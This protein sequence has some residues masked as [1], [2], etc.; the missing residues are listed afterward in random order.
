M[1]GI[2]GHLGECGA[3]LTAASIILAV[4]VFFLTEG[5]RSIVR[6]RPLGEFSLLLAIGGTL[7]PGSIAI[8]SILLFTITNLSPCFFTAL[9]CLLVSAIA[10]LIFFTYLVLGFFVSPIRPLTRWLFNTGTQVL[11]EHDME[12]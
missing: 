8:F 6:D 4:G 11:Y 2:V 5:V 1:S 3:L 12:D 9:Y 10:I 7:I